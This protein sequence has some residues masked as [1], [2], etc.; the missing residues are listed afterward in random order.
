MKAITPGRC[1]RNVLLVDDD[2]VLEGMRS[3]PGKTRASG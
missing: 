3:E 1:C 2:L